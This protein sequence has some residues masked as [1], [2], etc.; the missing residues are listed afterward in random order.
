MVVAVQHF[1]FANRTVL[2]ALNQRGIGDGTKR[3][4]ADIL[5]RTIRVIHKIISRIRGDKFKITLPELISPVQM[6]FL[7]GANVEHY[8]CTPYI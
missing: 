2:R 7:K 5:H 3:L 6:T 4:H 8:H 1:F